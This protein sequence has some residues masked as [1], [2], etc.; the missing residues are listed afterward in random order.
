MAVPA[1]HQFLQERACVSVAF[2]VELGM[3]K[4]TLQSLVVN[5]PLQGHWRLEAPFPSLVISLLLFPLLA[6][7]SC[8]TPAPDSYPFTSHSPFLCFFLSLSKLCSDFSVFTSHTARQLHIRRW[9]KLGV[10]GNQVIARWF[11]LGLLTVVVMLRW[12]AGGVACDYMR[13]LLNLVD[14]KTDIHLKSSNRIPR[15]G[16]TC[17]VDRGSSEHLCYPP[18]C[19]TRM[20]L[21]YLLGLGFSKE[22]KGVLRLLCKIQL[23]SNVDLQGTFQTAHTAHSSANKIPIE[24]DQLCMFLM[25]S[26]LSNNSEV[27]LLSLFLEPTVENSFKWTFNVYERCERYCVLRIYDNFVCVFFTGT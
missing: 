3:C 20:L 14:C 5:Q 22:S 10:H 15:Y 19:G 26:L 4:Q 2:R 16:C 21:S 13:P 8:F 11:F 9:L 1:S 12:S 7:S 24:Q 23:Q 25:S 18:V 17:I 6:A 27:S